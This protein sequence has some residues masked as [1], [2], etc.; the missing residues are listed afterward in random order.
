[1]FDL[2]ELKSLKL[3][4]NNIQNIPCWISKLSTLTVLDLSM[5]KLCAIPPE[6]SDLIQLQYLNLESNKNLNCFP[7]RIYQLKQLKTLI[8][9]STNFSSINFANQLTLLNHLEVDKCSLTSASDLLYLSELR[10]FKASFNYIDSLQPSC[11]KLVNLE[12][13][14]LGSNALHVILASIEGLKCLS[15]LDW[16]YNEVSEL[17]DEFG[18]LQCLQK[19]YLQGNKLTCFPKPILKLRNLDTLNLSYNSSIPS[20]PKELSSQLPNLTNLNLASV[21]LRSVEYLTLI[22]NLKMC[23]ISYNSHLTEKDILFIQRFYNS[24][25]EE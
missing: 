15:I 2:T 22:K 11:F 25:E 3:S 4:F 17:P 14:E 9:N 24:K 10:T 5:N 20:I 13:L 21:N 19:L 18:N 16:S 6:I 7:N 8:L 1:M 12:V 23:N